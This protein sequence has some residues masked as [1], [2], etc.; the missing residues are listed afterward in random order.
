MKISGESYGKLTDRVLE[1]TEQGKITEWT[2][3]IAQLAKRLDLPIAMMKWSGSPRIV[4]A[5]VVEFSD[6]WNVIPQ[7]E[8]ELTQME[9]NNN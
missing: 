5:S 7:L 9:E 8:A 4:A 1:A 3:R 6:N 2:E